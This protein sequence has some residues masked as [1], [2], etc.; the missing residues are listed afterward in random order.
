MSWPHILSLSR[1]AAG[2]VVAAL[3]LAQPGNAY[4]LAAIVFGLAAVT[5]LLDGR[6]ARHSQTVS[7]LGVFLDTTADKVMVGLTLVALA[8]SGMAAAWIPMV[9]LGREFLITGLRSYAASQGQVISS[10]IWGKGKAA[11][12]MVA[13]TALLVAA[14]GRSGA[15]LANLG[16]HDLWIKL[17]ILSGWLLAVSALLTVISGAR[18]IVDAWPLF[19][20]PAPVRR[21][22]T[23]PEIAR[24]A[25]RR[26]Q[27][28]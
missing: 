10:H 4:L 16:N 17:D 9:I 26:D 7:P 22:R 6:L 28:R 18:Y 27:A 15:L 20:E 13:I 23:Q 25:P 5:D 8:L 3:V 19:R 11:F 14:D 2:P 1:V 12:T 21:E 24:I